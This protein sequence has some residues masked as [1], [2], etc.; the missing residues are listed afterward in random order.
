M[1][2]ENDTVL[3][4]WTQQ[5]PRGIVIPKRDQPNHTKQTGG[6]NAVLY[7]VLTSQFGIPPRG[8]G[9]STGSPTVLTAGQ[10]LNPGQ[11]LQSPD[12]RY[13]LTYQADGNLV[14]YRYDG[15]VAWHTHTYGRSAGRALMQADGNFVVYDTA[16]I[17]AWHSTTHGNPGAY[18]LFNNSGTISVANAL[19]L[20][21]WSSPQPPWNVA[22]PSDPGGGT[23][24]GGTGG[25]A[26]TLTAGMRLYAGQ[27]VHSADRRFALTYQ[28]DGNLVLYGPNGVP[29]WSAHV[30]NAPGYAEMQVDGNFVAYDATGSPR[31]ASNTSG[32]INA[33]LVVHN[34]GNVA[35]HASNG[36]TVWQTGTGGS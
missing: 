6:M 35:I 8:P 9:G 5:F 36:L 15:A 17:A 14:I 12:R 34:D 10:A 22:P 29:R 33:R 3:P 31:W 1:C 2:W 19:G 27:A 4:V 26:D 32:R 16:G 13:R 30:F 11:S 25:S 24:G 18:L 23:G 21:I 20:P 7:E 28:S